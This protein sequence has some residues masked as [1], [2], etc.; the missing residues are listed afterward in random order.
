MSGPIRIDDAFMQHLDYLETPVWIFDIEQE[1]MF[2]ANPPAIKLWGADNKSDLLARNFA[3]MT[4]AT[5]SR[6]GGYLDGFREGQRFVERWS[7]YPEDDPVTVDCSCSGVYL[8]DKRLAML[9]EGR[10]VHPLKIKADTLLMTEALRHTNTMVSVYT[11]EGNP[12]FRNPSATRTYGEAATEKNL[13]WDIPA[14]KENRHILHHALENDQVFSAQLYVKTQDGKRWHGLDARKIKD[15]ITGDTRILVN[16][17]DNTD[18]HQAEEAL[19]LNEARLEGLFNL[20]PVG[21]ALSDYETGAFLRVNEALS[22]AIAYTQEE[23]KALSNWDVT[24]DT[25]ADEEALNLENLRTQGNFGPYEKEYIRKD[26]SQFPVLVKGLLLKD[27][28]GKDLIWSIIEDMTSRKRSEE[29]L[30]LA[31]NVFTHSHEGIII[32][33]ANAKIVDVNDAFTLLTGYSRKDII[34]QHPRLLR[35]GMHA[36]SFYGEM[37]RQ[38]EDKGHWH[39]EIWNK[40]KDGSIF[41]GMLTIS[42]VHDL[43]G[44]VRNYVGLFN[45]ITAQKK[46]QSQLEHLAHYD[47]LTNLPNRVLLTDRLNQGLALQSRNGKHFAVVYL[48][49]DGFKEVNDS[50]GHNVGDQLLAHLAARLTQTLRESDTVARLG[51]DEFVLLLN[52]LDHPDD[53]YPLLQRVLDAAAKPTP[54][55]GHIHNVSASLGVSFYPQSIEVGPDQLLRQADQAMYQAKLSGKN[56]YQIFGKNMDRNV[57]NQNE[58]LDQIHRGLTENEFVLLYQPQVN[59]RTGDIVGTEALIRWQHPVKG[60]LLPDTFLPELED[61]PLAVELDE[62]V[63]R[64]SLSQMN[65]WHAQGFNIQVSVNISAR[66]LQRTDFKDHIASLLSHHPF[67]KPEL[68][69]FEVTESSALSDIEHVSSVIRSC[70]ELGIRFALD[71][72]GTGYSSLTYLKHL[73]ADQLKID[74]SFLREM[75]SNPGD[76]AIVKAIL[77]CSGA[78]RCEVIAEGVESIEQG[79]TLL[80]LGCELAQGYAFAYPMTADEL[81]QWIQNETQFCGIA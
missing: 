41:A 21:I 7:F 10:A 60:V 35:S 28:S 66:Y 19:R 9:V 25:Y 6:L 30:K 34:A 56:R 26:G 32:T 5:R 16:E 27:P 13:L 79:E 67:V 40:K 3:D 64:K 58:N 48:D 24:P 55:G 52:N 22:T 23:C 1:A 39:G 49:L 44:E 72:F 54:I 71:D 73:P 81:H 38:L 14:D 17:R 77:G 15:P 59:L 50:H 57:R 69:M 12:L 47:A 31:A 42:S 43:N 75:L 33:D 36:P 11:Q 74:R 18:Q 76:L 20:S 68:L 80:Q 63:I 61:T 62:W 37:W 29:K 2:W 51:G 53:C 70:N 4:E 78:F 46:Y 65:R 8:P 45:D